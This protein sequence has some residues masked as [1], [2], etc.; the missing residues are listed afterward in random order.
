VG[1]LFPVGDKLV[2]EYIGERLKSWHLEG[3]EDVRDAVERER[4]ER[5]Q[6]SKY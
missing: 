5:R 1:A 6:S 2:A 4:N 3:P